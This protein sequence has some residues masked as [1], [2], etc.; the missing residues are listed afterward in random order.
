[1]TIF[2]YP[3]YR[4]KALDFYENQTYHSYLFMHK[5]Q[6]DVLLSRANKSSRALK[7]TKEAVALVARFSYTKTE[8]SHKTG[9]AVSTIHQAMKRWS[10][11]KQIPKQKSTFTP[12]YLKVNVSVNG[13]QNSK[14]K[15]GYELIKS[16]VKMSEAAR[17]VGVSR[18]ALHHYI[19]THST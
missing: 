2:K 12:N 6:R 4:H 11:N 19:K 7:S 13:L 17:Q 9:V 3:R 18:Q 5:E 15:E 14:C 8:A 10:D 16:G 1:M